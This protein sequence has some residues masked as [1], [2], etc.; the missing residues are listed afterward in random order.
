MIF[1]LY[2]VPGLVLVFDRWEDWI[3]SGPPF[4][5]ARRGIERHM[6]ETR[7]PSVS[8]A[9]AKGGKIVWEESF[10]WAD[11]ER[12]I[13]ATPHT[14]YAL[15]STTKALTATGLMVLVERGLLDL[16]Q[17]I[18]SYVG[19]VGLQAYEG[20]LEGVT[21]RRLFTHTSGLPECWAHYY[22]NEDKP[23][24]T[25]EELI[26]RYGIL[27]SSPGERYI[28][29]SVGTGLAG[30]VIER[31]SGKSFSEFMRS[32][33]FGPLGLTS[34]DLITAPYDNPDIAQKYAEG[35]RLAFYDMDFHAGGSGWASVHD[36]VRFGMFHLKDHLPDQKAI[37]SDRTIDGMYDSVDPRL[38]HHHIHL[39]WFQYR[40]R[41][42]KIMESGG[43]VIGGKISFRL[44]PSEDVVVVVMSNGEEADTQR[45]S[46]WILNRLLPGVSSF[47]ALKRIPE[48][49]WRITERKTTSRDIF[50]G[51]W[52]GE[53]RTYQGIIPIRLTIEPQ[54]AWLQ[55]VNGGET[56]GKGIPTMPDRPVRILGDTL[57]ASFDT[58]I[59][60]EDSARAEHRVT[61]KLT[62]RGK[63]LS[64]P[65]YAESR[66]Y[67]FWLPSYAY[68]RRSV[69]P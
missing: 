37:L 65:A 67:Y 47:G 29:S 40:Y 32:E 7:I 55:V 34:T 10:G 61:L 54:A 15:A 44:A 11:R 12:G 13:K 48:S 42:F 52:I 30:L 56:A 60:T 46:D 49:I 39:P 50:N 25:I 22:E 16:D 17:P 4:A 51:R 3:S 41:G 59:P 1:L 64:G 68:L 6:R 24:P 21:V 33:V 19:D 53:I 63:R 38:P 23:H 28:Y 14:M 2:V 26:R 27:V 62:L 58:R 66:G 20:A 31:I 45:I 35:K 18:E 9:A 5:H 69:P 57:V 36:L 8:V 43:H